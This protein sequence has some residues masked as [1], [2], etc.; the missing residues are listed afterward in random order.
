MSAPGPA[1]PEDAHRLGYLSTHGGDDTFDK[2]DHF[3]G[4][5]AKAERAAKRGHLDGVSAEQAQAASGTVNL[6]HRYGNN[7]KDE[8]VLIPAPTADPQDPLNLPLWQRVAAMVMLQMFASFGQSAVS[9]F[10]AILDFLEKEYMESEGKSEQDILNLSVMPTL[11]QGLAN[12]ALGPL[13]LAIGRRPVYLAAN[14]ILLLAMILA[15]NNHTYEQ[16]LAYRL[17]M[18]CSVGVGQTLVPL[19]ISELFFVHSRGT[20]L[21]WSGAVN[22]LMGLVWGTF[23]P[24]V[25]GSI[26]WRNL[27]YVESGLCGTA[28]LFG[29]FL[30]PETKYGRPVEAFNGL[31]FG[32]SASTESSPDDDKS[33]EGETQHVEGDAT[34][35]LVQ[36]TA[37]TR[38][39]VDNVNYKPR[40]WLSDLRPFQRS[41]E[42]RLYYETF[43]HAVQLLL[44]PNILLLCGLNFWFLTMT[45]VHSATYPRVL[46]GGWGWNPADVGYIQAG[47]ILDMA[48]TVPLV[49]YLSDWLIKYFAK[50][51]RGV[52]EPEVRLLTFI[53]P[54]LLGVIGM[55]MHGYHQAYPKQM[56]WFV[57]VYLFGILNFCF[58]ACAVGTQIYVIDALPLRS[59]PAIIIVNTFR[60]AL[61]FAFMG[62]FM[63]TIMSLGGPLKA[64]CTFGGI[65]AAFLAVVV[66]MFFW[67]KKVRLF[68]LRFVLDIGKDGKAK[69]SS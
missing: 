51:R 36:I 62:S 52:H 28:F 7:N 30:M 18:G 6:L 15:A 59:G 19:M 57:Q 40:T 65:G 58:S 14:I 39:E 41:P 23:V 17:L 16:H 37:L 46:I 68:T 48:L 45:I 9:S 47:A 34:P 13:A 5:L 67:G 44:F 1:S 8:I 4:A 11:T 31:G 50:R 69:G 25:V 63:K 22:S 60:G 2:I 64:W 55:C 38:P 54:C 49:G 61:A 35:R 12:L 21:A 3:P 43:Y 42:W 66:S 56:H 10:S 33:K 26:G 24:K 29:I 27:Y 20:I 53:I 32:R